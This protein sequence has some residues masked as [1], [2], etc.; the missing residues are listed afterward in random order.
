MGEGKEVCVGKTELSVTASQQQGLEKREEDAG[1][2]R[3]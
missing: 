2:E 1:K 3:K